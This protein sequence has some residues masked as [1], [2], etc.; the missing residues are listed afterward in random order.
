[1]STPVRLLSERE[2][3]KL[4]CLIMDNGDAAE[5]IVAIARWAAQAY[6]TMQSVAFYDWS[7]NDPDAC[8]DIERLRTLLAAATPPEDAA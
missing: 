1:M 5:R 2:I 6:A 7:E 4:S 8:A 3:S